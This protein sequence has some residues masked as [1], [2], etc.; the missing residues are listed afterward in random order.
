MSKYNADLIED[1][2][3]FKTEVMAILSKLNNPD[4]VKVAEKEMKSFIVH[5]VKDGERLQILIN[6]ISEDNSFQK[7]NVRKDQIKL[8]IIIAEVFQFQ[9]L[10][11]QPKIFLLMNKKIKDGDTEMF[12]TISDTY[13]GVLDYALK[14]TSQA[15]ETFTISECFKNLF[16][17][18]RTGSQ[19]SQIG[20]S[21]SIS[22]I[23]QSSPTNS[24]SALFDSILNRILDNLRLENCKCICEMLECLLSLLLTNQ[25]KVSQHVDIILPV[26]YPTYNSPKW[27][28]RKV[29][30]DALYSLSIICPDDL[31]NHKIELIE[32][33]SPL[34]LDKN[35]TVREAAMATMNAL[36]DLPGENPVPITKRRN[37][38]TS[39]SMSAIRKKKNTS[40]QNTSNEFEHSTLF[41]NGSPQRTSQVIEKPNSPRKNP[42]HNEIQQQ[43]AKRNLSKEKRNP[44]KDKRAT[45]AEIR[46]SKIKMKGE[47]KRNGAQERDLSKQKKQYGINRKNINPG[48]LKRNGTDEETFVN[49]QTNDIEIFVDDAPPIKDNYILNDPEENLDPQNEYP[50]AQKNLSEKDN[51]NL[52]RIQD[53]YTEDF[54]ENPFLQNDEERDQQKFPKK[55]PDSTKEISRKNI[56]MSKNKRASL[57]NID[58]NFTRKNE[59]KENHRKPSELEPEFDTLIANKIIDD[60]EIIDPRVSKNNRKRES[61]ESFQQRR[62]DRK[63]DLSN[64]NQH[65]LGNNSNQQI[66]NQN[67]LNNQIDEN[68]LNHIEFLKNENAVLKDSQKSQ[69]N[70]VTA[71][72]KQ[73]KE[74]QQQINYLINKVNYIEPC[75][76]SMYQMNM[77]NRM[78]NINPGM[79]TQSFPV[80]I[81]QHPVL[82]SSMNIQQPFDNNMPQMNLPQQSMMMQNNLQGLGPANAPSFNASNYTNNQF[83]M[84]NQRTDKSIEF[85]N[86]AINLNNEDK[87]SK[88]LARKDK[89]PHNDNSDISNI[90]NQKDMYDEPKMKSNLKNYS[91]I[92]EHPKNQRNPDLKIE[93]ARSE[94]KMLSKKISND[95]FEYT[96]NDSDF[97]SIFM[98]NKQNLISKADEKNYHSKSS[99][100]EFAPINQPNRN[101]RLKMIEKEDSKSSES[102]NESAN[103]DQN[104]NSS[105]TE[106][107]DILY[108]NLCNSDNSSLLDFL[109]NHEIL[110]QFTEIDQENLNALF[111]RLLDL[112][113]KNPS[114][115]Q[116]CMLWI[117]RYIEYEK[118]STQEDAYQVYNIIAK[119][120]GDKYMRIKKELKFIIDNL[121]K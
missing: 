86:N 20:A 28:A 19:A 34:K 107:N 91:D 9:I 27:N 50:S 61:N 46:D 94:K 4:A 118:I 58:Q 13:S 7:L 53:K 96:K 3:H 33:I 82:N 115:S 14:N 69:E 64:Q 2:Q 23:I 111:D 85:S 110:R 103:D 90:T 83:P 25:L 88:W 42:F 18:I 55:I 108:K 44:S 35:K 117:E 98:N 38:D 78:Y 72:M 57:E 116:I 67:I 89:G 17:I 10:E 43:Q 87:N 6:N 60:P 41:D 75:L 66:P 84:D 31:K 113:L 99:A 29:A 100:E 114:N 109:S 120:T 79:P 8:F 71:I 51:E 24:I 74:Q 12:H 92:Q 30:L 106:I 59:F 11:Y 101:K 112:M 15:E 52:Q 21:I 121:N 73:L 68:L 37:P 5:Q 1:K 104:E 45:R 102:E 36:K 62:I 39:Q 32:A 26:L 40:L 70:L 54:K 93:F 56:D 95:F 119:M 80:V 76:N 49:D 16:E 97:D 48:F 22:K 77:Q 63:S 65:L 47:I 81:Q 105:D